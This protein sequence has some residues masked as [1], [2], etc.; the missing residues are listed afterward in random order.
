MDVACFRKLVDFMCSIH[1]VHDPQSRRAFVFSAIEDSALI[2]QIDFEDSAFDFCCLLIATLYHY[3]YLSNGQQ[4]LFALLKGIENWLGEVQKKQLQS[5][6]NQIFNLEEQ[7][8][9]FLKIADF[10]V[11]YIGDS[12]PKRK[13]R[14]N[15][16]EKCG[17]R[18]ETFIKSIN[19]SGTSH[20]FI[21]HL[22]DRFHRY[23]PDTLLM[24]LK[25]IEDNVEEEKKAAFQ[26]FRKSLYPDEPQ[27][28]LLQNEPDDK[29]S[30]LLASVADCILTL[31]NI[32]DSSR[33]KHLLLS[34]GLDELMDRIQ[35]KGTLNTFI[36]NLI[37]QLYS[38]GA[39]S[40]GRHA[41]QHALDALLE[42][43][44]QL[45]GVDRKQQIHALRNRLRDDLNRENGLQG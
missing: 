23:N 5:L 29:T 37:P 11:N 40:S 35:L 9:I 16:L 43:A 12:I 20:D 27:Q 32:H 17:L 15:L 26:S 22:T 7:K 34:S 8:P 44:E 19:F 4:A 18:E 3:K 42:G 38:H 25:G 39:L 6:C 30:G 31:P 2:S 41:G 36:H 33:R 24:L 14:L 28:T 1:F 13:D 45:V 21:Y 10:L